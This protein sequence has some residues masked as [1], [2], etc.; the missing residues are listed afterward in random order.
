MIWLTMVGLFIAAI[1]LPL[2]NEY[3]RSRLIR[4]WCKSLLSAFNIRVIRSGFI[5]PTDR[6]LHNVMVVANHISW[7]DIHALNSVT[8]LKFIAKSEIKNWP[9]FG[10]LAKTNAIFIDRTKRHEA[11]NTVETLTE[12]LKAGAN[13]CLF[14][15]GTTTTGNEVMPFK[16]SLIQ[17]AIQAESTIYPVAIYYPHPNGGSNTQMAYAGQIT[18]TES[19]RQVLLQRAP[20]VELRFLA[21]IQVKNLTEAEKDRR[22]LTAH[23]QQLITNALFEQKA[24]PL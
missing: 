8:P 15:E 9:I 24:K 6:P 2:V 3:K 14:P 12:N 21:P 20:V 17:A 4:W 22:V 7:S 11:A 23:I 5:P 1:P 10:Y 13:V 19:M 16:S 18:L